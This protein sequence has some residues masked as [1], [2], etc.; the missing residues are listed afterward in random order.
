LLETIPQGGPW[1]IVPMRI[2][3]FILLG[4]EG[5]VEEARAEYKATLDL[6]RRLDYPYG[7]ALVLSAL[8]GLASYPMDPEEW[9]SRL[10]TALAIFER[11]G[12]NPLAERTRR[13]LEQALG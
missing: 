4:R 3:K 7:E 5:D 10:E 1:S 8:G 2:V 11:L 9:R 6:T 13:A 12:A